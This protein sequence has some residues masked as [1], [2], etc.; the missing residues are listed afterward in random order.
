MSLIAF[1]SGRSPGL[2]T[3]VHAMALTWPKS[4]RSIIAELDPDGGA[5]AAR[6]ALPPDP[7]L[8][9]LA[10]AGRR[11]LVA[12]QVLDHCRPLT[13]GS[14]VLVGPTSPD[15]A[16]SALATLGPRLAEALDT[17]PGF[18]VLADCGRLES[19]S[20]ALEIISGAPYVL[21]V[22]E[23]TVEG[24]AHL[25][26]R[27]AALPLPAG[28]VA[29]IAVGDRPYHPSEVSRVLNLP[30][31]GVIDRDPRG[32]VQLAEGRPNW[33]SPLLR[34]AAAIT[35]ALVSHLPPLAEDGQDRAPMTAPAMVAPDVDPLGGQA[36][37]RQWP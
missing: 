6:Y 34:S 17:T 13:D 36:P 12:G 25:A 5:F 11:G 16:A 8:V 28:R 1:G 10:A 22:V 20:P 2:T 30:M 14:P 18:D 19:R 24:V 29:L 4:R 31:L 33:R 21:L 37:G 35:A 26:A 15:R 27:L 9:S 32:A 23:P 7:G 3:L